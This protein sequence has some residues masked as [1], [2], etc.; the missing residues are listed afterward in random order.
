M[1]NIIRRL[2][3]GHNV[4]IRIYQVIVKFT[5]EDEHVVYIYS[6]IFVYTIK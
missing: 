5:K 2:N 4:Q 1:T 6:R 3:K